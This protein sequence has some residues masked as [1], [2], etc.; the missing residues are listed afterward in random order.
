MAEKT[1][2]I[3]N[4][5]VVEGEAQYKAALGQAR[6]ALAET[7]SEMRA[8]KAEFAGQ[9]ESAESLQ[10]KIDVLTRQYAANETQCRTLEEYLEKTAKAFG[11]NSK[12][13]S[14]MRIKLNNARAAMNTTGN[15]L[16]SL[17]KQ[18]DAVEG[19]SEDAGS[20]MKDAQDDIAGIGES[21][22][23]AAPGVQGL[24]DTLAQLTGLDLGTLSIGAAGAAAAGAVKAGMEAGNEQTQVRGQMAAYTGKTGE[25]LAAL[26]EIGKDVYRQGFGENL[27]D[28][29]QSVATVNVYTG[30]GGGELQEAT[31]YAMRLRDVFGYEIPESARTAQQMMAVFGTSAQEAYG[32]MVAGA[33]QGADKNGNL[34]DTINEYAPYYE[35]AG[36]SA[37]EFMGTLIAGAQ[38]GVYDVDKIGDAMKE[39]TLRIADGSETTKETL[40]SLG[41]EAADVPA[42]FAEGGDGASLAFDMVIDRLLAIEDPL[43][44]SQAGVALF[45]TQWEDTGGAV[46]QIFDKIGAGE[47]DVQA[48]LE[49]LNATRMDD[50]E[51]GLD[52]IKNHVEVSAGEF[53][54]PLA[55]G[56]ANTLN[57]VADSLDKAEAKSDQAQKRA[58]EASEAAAN[59][60]EGMYA[61]LE[62][63]DEQI[64]AAWASGDALEA[65]TLE[66]KKQ[67]LIDE[68]AATKQEVITGFD[69]MGSEAAAAFGAT[70]G[71]F[72]AAA[73]LV[74]QTAI[75]AMNAKEPDMRDAGQEMGEAG[76]EGLEEG[77]D[78]GYDIGANYGDAVARGLRS[79]ESSVRAAAKKL[80]GAADESVKAVMMIHSP[81]RKGLET[82][83]NYGG[84]VAQ[85]I[86][87]RERD[88]AAAGE[89]LGHAAD[90]G[91]QEALSAPMSV[92]RT[93]AGQMNAI[94]EEALARAVKS[95]LNGMALQIDGRTAGYLL[96]EGVSVAEYDRAAATVSGRS[97]ALRI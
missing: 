75:D 88:V 53:F 11:E 62:A 10:A 35:K 96:E 1:N 30:A 93:D 84:A 16:G 29:S 44:R 20:A 28:A 97:A 26:E 60:T 48:A 82:G 13:A 79:K 86:R 47:A 91:T 89:I 43:K 68:I 8:V 50:L 5:I 70:D 74:S 33:Q 37:Q 21:A 15:E 76:E 81:S 92:A 72:D 90:I 61:Q 7:K 56:L 67:Q 66:A 49:S 39:F 9:E 71:E 52:R 27:A 23:K 12:E 31:Q 4:R 41:L 85:G 18:L 58:E 73:D 17:R 40:K 80:G 14:D 34:L 54:T 42:K 78:D 6:Q 59:A 95:A 38:S 24:A 36:K 87:E 45:G 83:A 46:L 51:V 3:K 64:N 69:K 57:Q 65:L 22:E 77:L 63:L 19:A 55:T 25:E 2:T 94:T 32:L